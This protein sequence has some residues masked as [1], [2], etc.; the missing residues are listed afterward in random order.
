MTIWNP[1]IQGLVLSDKEDAVLLAFHLLEDKKSLIYWY[2][3]C[4]GAAERFGLPCLSV[5]SQVRF[6][7]VPFLEENGYD[8]GEIEDYLQR[9]YDKHLEQN[10]AKSGD[11]SGSS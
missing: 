3:R 11:I 2:T 10:R 9:A 1:L 4:E 7:Y 8:S 5:L 6:L